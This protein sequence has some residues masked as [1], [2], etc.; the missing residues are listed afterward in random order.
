MN[1]RKR[2][3]IRVYLLAGDA[4]TLVAY[5]EIPK[6]GVTAV[7]QAPTLLK[8][9]L[10]FLQEE[11]LQS[12]RPQKRYLT[13]LSMGPRHAVSLYGKSYSTNRLGWYLKRWI[14]QRFMR[15][16]RP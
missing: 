12:Y 7:R 13:I 5:P 14:D 10:N 16:Y 6:N 2:S 8:N 1:S 9:L 11:P 3:I 4:A 15:K